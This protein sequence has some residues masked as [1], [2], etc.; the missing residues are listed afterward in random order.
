M[1]YEKEGR[2][3]QDEA[4]Q[5][6]CAGVQKKNV[7]NKI[8]WSVVF[9]IIAVLT[10]W[11][12][13][14]QNKD[15]SLA[16]FSEFLRSLKLPWLIA[17]VLVMIVYVLF[18]GLAIMTISKSFGYKRGLCKGL[19]YS[20]ADIYF[21]AI[22]PS[23]TGGQPAS[24]YLMMKDRIPGSV[25]T[26]VLIANL[27][28]YTFAI[29]IIGALGFIINPRM[30]MNF[31]VLSRVLIIFG[32]FCQVF[33]A[34]FFILLLR[35]GEWLYSIG[36]VL[37]LGLAKIHL[38]RNLDRKRER[39]RGYIKN[40]SRY[41]S[42]LK[43]KNKMLIKA[44]IY[45][46]LQ[47]FSLIL[48]TVLCFLSTGGD[49]SL[50]MSVFVA[51]SM[52]VLGSNTIPIP[53]AMGVIDFLI[54]DVFSTMMTASMATNLDLL[55]RTVSFYFCVILCGITFLVRCLMRQKQAEADSTEEG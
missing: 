53:G 22:T 4:A 19:S 24:A 16:S 3:M 51:Q 31:S 9:I 27:V 39:L 6:K 12:V 33:M 55:S 18:E 38:V 10:V 20:A 8:L 15:F 44:L 46:V 11:A 52:V 13:T 45:N 35:K 34:V 25:T 48:V 21:S 5:K 50:V 7:R 23:A 43:G 17:A 28:M 42:Q 37:L 30:F 47:R 29:I 36:N 54:L 1:F 41:S 14:A 40:Y 2:V 32:C 49:L 26:V